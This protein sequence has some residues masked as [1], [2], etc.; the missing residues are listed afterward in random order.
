MRT[1][2]P[3]NVIERRITLLE[4]R[5]ET[6]LLGQ[7]LIA[8]ILIDLGSQ[9]LLSS[10]AVQRLQAHSAAVT[11]LRQIQTAIPAKPVSPFVV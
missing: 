4:H 5:V 1:T 9:G 3:E 6:L 2:S 10:V 8:E 11:T 7:H